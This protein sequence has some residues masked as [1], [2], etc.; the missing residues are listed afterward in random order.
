MDW[1]NR[2]NQAFDY[3]EA[4]LYELDYEVISRITLCPVGILQRFF[5]LNVGQTLTEYV[6]ARR[7]SEAGLTLQFSDRKVMDVAVDCGYE[8]AKAFS[9]AFKRFHG[10][11]PTDARQHGTVLQVYPRFQFEIKV[12]Q[13]KGANLMEKIQALNAQLA[14]DPDNILLLMERMEAYF[15][16]KEYR[17]AIADLKKAEKSHHSDYLGHDRY[18]ADISALDKA[19]SKQAEA[20][21]LHFRGCIDLSRARFK[22]AEESINQAIALDP[23]NSWFYHSICEICFWQGKD[24]E[25]GLQAMENAIRLNPEVAWHYDKRGWCRYNL[26]DTEGM[27]QDW[28]TV[29]RLDYPKH[30]GLF[31]YLT[32]RAHGYYGEIARVFSEIHEQNPTDQDILENLGYAVFHSKQ[33]E[34]SVQIQD[35]LIAMDAQK[36]GHWYC[37][38]NAHFLVGNY[39]E[40]ITDFTQLMALEGSETPHNLQRRSAAYYHTQ[41]YANAV[42]DLDKAIKQGCCENCNMTFRLWRGKSHLKLGNAAEAIADFTEA[43]TLN[44]DTALSRLHE[45]RAEAYRLLGD[46]ANAQADLEKSNTF[47]DASDVLWHWH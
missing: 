33:Y 9:V 4:N 10:V 44:P 46:D 14:Q 39:A 22:E 15:E 20:F 37:R 7:L 5:V 28:L 19:T 8:S 16:M 35:K 25:K 42:T 30:K 43:L 6:K 21:H 12:I 23:D 24:W 45:L 13:R 31:P 18:E 3:I 26:D 11:T 34:R 47:K 36:P 40:A 1:A 32:D 38:G 27:V 2:L 17:Q 29:F 41:Q